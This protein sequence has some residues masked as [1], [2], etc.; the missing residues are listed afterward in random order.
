MLV[1][2]LCLLDLLLTVGVI[3]RLREHT[4]II[5]PIRQQ[6][7]IRTGD[8]VGEFSVVSVDGEP[9]GRDFLADDSVVAFFAPDCQPCKAVL[10]DFIRLAETDGNCRDHR[11]AVVIGD[12]SASRE[13]V[14]ML[15]PVAQV[16]VEEPL[17]TVSTAFRTSGTPTV[18]RVGISRGRTVVTSDRVLAMPT[19]AAV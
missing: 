9:L 17:G 3:K 11:I 5:A 2:V 6:S 16:V 1:A 10:P 4:E 7:G 15:R 8:E 19:A 18:L 14:E 12:T 13:L